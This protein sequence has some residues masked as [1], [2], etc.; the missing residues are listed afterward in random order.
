MKINDGKVLIDGEW[1]D[2]ISGETLP[3]IDP[4]D[5]SQFGYIANCSKED[6]DLA[7]QSAQNA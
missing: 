4:S 5:G 6:V 7:V 3:V 2:S 1:Q